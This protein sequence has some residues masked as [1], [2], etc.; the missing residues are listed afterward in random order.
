MKRIAISSLATLVV[1]STLFVGCGHAHEW[2]EANCTTAKTCVQ[3]GETEGE[4]LGHTW[5]EATCENA[6]TCSVCGETQGEAL[7]HDYANATFDAA[8]TCK[9]CGATEG[10]PLSLKKLDFDFIDEHEGAVYTP[11][12]FVTYDWDE[13]WNI[14]A[15]NYDWDGSLI[16]DYMFNSLGY[17]IE[18]I[19]NNSNGETNI[20]GYVDWSGYEDDDVYIIIDLRDIQG[21]ELA[22]TEIPINDFA[23]SERIGLFVDESNKSYLV[24]N[25]STMEVYGSMNY[26][27]NTWST[28][29]D[30]SVLE[31]ETTFDKT[32]YERYFKKNPGVDYY[33][34]ATDD[35][36]WGFVDE[37][38]NMLKSY[39]DA[40]A[41]GK[42]GY[43][44]VSDD[45][46]KYSVIDKD[47]NIVGD[48]II[49]GSAV[50]NAPEGR[51][52]VYGVKNLAG[53]EEYYM[54]V[55]E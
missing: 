37:N 19:F 33:F 11:F 26:E 36:N 48:G 39:M 7:G 16:C 24:F 51:A 38:G 34:V 46:Q 40:S 42:S 29:G 14:K 22:K 10:S 3:C 49:E 53:E 32:A 2:Q 13:S 50:Y 45:R 17:G 5:G 8:K 4:P 21:N 18:R 25:T 52:D 41:F 20:F 28:D 6:K 27:T 55:C 54:I 31:P 47:F 1:I 43:A 23:E 9:N 12:G 30:I 35:N 15:S 44:F